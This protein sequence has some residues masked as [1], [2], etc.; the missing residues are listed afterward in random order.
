MKLTSQFKPNNRPVI[1]SDAQRQYAH[2]LMQ[3]RIHIN[4]DKDIKQSS[5]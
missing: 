2:L 1:F 5:N 3:I 4:L